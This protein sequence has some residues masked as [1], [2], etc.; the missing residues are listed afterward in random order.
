VWTSLTTSQRARARARARALPERERER[1]CVCACVCVCVCVCYI[2]THTHSLTLYNTH[3]HSHSH[4]RT[5]THTHT[6]TH[7]SP[8][9]A[10]WFGIAAICTDTNVSKC[11][12]LEELCHSDK[13]VCQCQCGRPGAG[14][15]NHD[16]SPGR[17]R[18]CARA[19]HPGCALDAPVMDLV[20]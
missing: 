9:P 2:H 10:L 4:A 11:L 17:T 6:H 5:R 1:L 20:S 8:A 15:G 3:T 16:D 13:A 19:C 18:T 7:T 12:L 14:G